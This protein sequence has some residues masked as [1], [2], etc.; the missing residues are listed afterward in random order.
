MNVPDIVAIEAI[1]EDVAPEI[2]EVDSGS[3]HRHLRSSGSDAKQIKEWGSDLRWLRPCF[4]D[5]VSNGLDLKLWRW[6]S[7]TLPNESCSQ[8]N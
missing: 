4:N 7:S 1:D 8:R 6:T 3:S 2:Q 5:V